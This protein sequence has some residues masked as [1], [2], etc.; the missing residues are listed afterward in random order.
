MLDMMGFW[1]PL[2]QYGNTAW[3]LQVI[4][5][6]GDKSTDIEQLIDKDDAFG[7]ALFEL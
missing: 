5:M 6:T 1:D 2:R 3:S 4:F 7:M